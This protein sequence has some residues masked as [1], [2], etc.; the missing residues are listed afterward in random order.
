MQNLAT[1]LTQERQETLKATI[2]QAQ[3]EYLTTRIADK[4]SVGVLVDA[5]RQITTVYNTKPANGEL[6]VHICSKGDSAKWEH[7]AQERRTLDGFLAKNGIVLGNKPFT[8][9]LNTLEANFPL[10]FA[11][12][13]EMTLN[14]ILTEF[15]PADELIDIAIAQYRKKNILSA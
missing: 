1:S 14:W 8:E 9:R 4:Y 3:T 13:K 10:A 7:F 6:Y 11:C 12:Y 5:N 15:W 2:Q